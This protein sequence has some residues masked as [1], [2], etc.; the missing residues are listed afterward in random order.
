MSITQA[1]GVCPAILASFEELSAPNNMANLKTPVGLIDAL[2]DPTNV[3]GVTVEQLGD[4]SNGHRKTVRIMHKQRQSISD[5]RTAKSCD[6]GTE[7]PRFETTFDVNMN[8]EIAIKVSEATVR[9][10]CDA[11]SALVAIPASVRSTNATAQNSLLIMREI[12]EEINMDIDALRQKIDDTGLEAFELNF[13]KYQGGSTY[14]EYKM[15][16]SAT[17]HSIVTAAFNTWKEDMRKIGMTG[18]PLVVGN[19]VISYAMDELGIGCCNI[20]GQ[21]IGKL[22]A[23]QDA[24]FFYDS[25]DLASHF[26]VLPDGAQPFISFFPKMAQMVTFNKYV[27]PTFSKPIGTMERGT[28]PDPKLPGLRYD[29]RMMPNE[30]G[31]YW[32]L[33]VDLD[34]DFY[35]APQTLFKSTDRLNGVNGIFK[36]FAGYVS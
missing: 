36:G 19:G 22:G 20:G 26:G 7:K 34:Y 35:F 31:E 3:A 32:D 6:S 4:G 14:K 24:K 17:D 9:R 10:L 28:L 27:G 25:A 2:L 13:G 33:W 1:N 8:A 16:K 11:Y 30:C 18:M 5:V 15:L 23:R 12:A 29:I 21:D